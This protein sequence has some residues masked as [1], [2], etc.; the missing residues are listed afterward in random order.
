MEK[1]FLE[2]CL[3]EGLSLDQIGEIVNRDPS[4]VSHH[5]RRHG[6]TPVGHAL[7]SPN[8][9]V[10]PDRLRELVDG[11]ATVREASEVLGVSYTTI[12]Y[13]IKRLGLETERMARLRE[14]KAAIDAG[15]TRVTMACPTHGE[16]P[17]FRRPDGNYRCTKCRSEAVV[18][19]RRRA[20][21]RLIERA[22]GRCELCGYDRHPGALHFHH[23]DPSSKRFPLSREGTTRSFAEAAEE[24]DKCVL[25]CGNCHA[26]VEGGVSEVPVSKG[27]AGTVETHEEPPA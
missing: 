12:R 17:F 26:E 2:R 10:D 5:M 27:P 9:R 16:V 24:A 14:S 8:G 21:L 15:L 4:T 1:E 25:L 20:K 11:G 7:H 22:G 13:W 19:W 23:L 3:A 18:K 6:L